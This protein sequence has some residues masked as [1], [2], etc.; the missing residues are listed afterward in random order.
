MFKLVQL[1]SWLFTTIMRPISAAQC[2]S[3][4]SV[5]TSFLLFTSFHIGCYMNMLHGSLP[6]SISFVSI[7]TF[8]LCT[9]CFTC[10]FHFSF[11]SLWGMDYTCSPCLFLM[12]LFLHF[13][14]KQ[15]VYC[16]VTVEY[17]WEPTGSFLKNFLLKLNLI[18]SVLE[19]TLKLNLIVDC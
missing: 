14:Y 9:T 19:L 15:V 3:V 10:T 12:F 5:M 6:F 18:K 16:S 7:F 8:L 17:Y 2:S 13:V 11:V 4:V 1:S